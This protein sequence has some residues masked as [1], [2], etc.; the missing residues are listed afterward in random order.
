MHVAGTLFSISPYALLSYYWFPI[1]LY[2]FKKH[3]WYEAVFPQYS[4]WPITWERDCEMISVG[5]NFTQKFLIACSFFFFSIFLLS[6]F[7][8]DCLDFNFLEFGTLNLLSRLFF[9]F[10]L[11][12][13]LDI[14]GLIPASTT[15]GYRKLYHPLSFLM[16]YIY[17]L[18]HCFSWE[19]YNSWNINKPVH[20]K[21]VWICICKILNLW[22]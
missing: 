16:K 13:F 9:I 17:Y 8:S 4:Y 11:F 5:L 1:F 3:I 12:F 22:Y 2:F 7:F 6:F 15:W 14:L 19:T 20:I 18:S 21:M 10:F